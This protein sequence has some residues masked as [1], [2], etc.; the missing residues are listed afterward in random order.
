MTTLIQEVEEGLGREAPLP[1]SERIAKERREEMVAEARERIQARVKAEESG[2]PAVDF[3]EAASSTGISI[4]NSYSELGDPIIDWAGE[5][6]DTALIG[7]SLILALLV[8]VLSVMV[9]RLSRRNKRM[10]ESSFFSDKVVSGIGRN[11]ETFIWFH[12]NSP[13]DKYYRQFLVDLKKL[14]KKHHEEGGIHVT[15]NEGWRDK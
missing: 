9:L 14:V 4:G 5:G 2:L 1:R 3:S 7:G 6:K 11:N 15:M 8:V 10:R 12:R 13:N